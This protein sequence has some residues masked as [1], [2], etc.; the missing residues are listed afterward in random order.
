M[1][2]ETKDTIIRM[3]KAQAKM[4][5]PPHKRWNFFEDEEEAKQALKEYNEEVSP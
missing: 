3:M 4:G 5:I 1:E 2:Q